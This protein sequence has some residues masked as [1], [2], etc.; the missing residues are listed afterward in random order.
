MAGSIAARR[1]VL[2]GDVRQADILRLRGAPDQMVVR[3]LEAGQHQRAGRQVV[4]L[5]ALEKRCDIGVRADRRDA[6]VDQRDRARLGLC[7]V[8]GED[9][10]AAQHH[11]LVLRE[12]HR[13]TEQKRDANG[14]QAGLP[15]HS[16][17]NDLPGVL[18]EAAKVQGAPCPSREPAYLE[19]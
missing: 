18:D 14:K 9:A 1:A 4:D 7:L 16:R 12:C 3:I 13:R 2:V 19:G 6:P 15:R 11:S 8:H 10:R 17:H 5:G